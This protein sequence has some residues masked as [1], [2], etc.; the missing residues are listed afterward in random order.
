MQLCVD[1]GNSRIKSAFFDEDQIL[2]EQ[3]FDTLEEGLREWEDTAF[4]HFE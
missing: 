2:S 1:I 4:S 3:H